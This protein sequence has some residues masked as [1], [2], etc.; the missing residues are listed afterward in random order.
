MF[1]SSTIIKIIV[2]SLNSRVFLNLTNSRAVF[3]SYILILLTEQKL[4]IMV[5]LE[6]LTILQVMNDRQARDA[7]AFTM[8]FSSLEC[9]I[10]R[11]Q[12]L[13]SA[14]AWKSEMPVRFNEGTVVG[15]NLN[16]KSIF[17]ASGGRSQVPTL[18]T[19]L[20]FNRTKISCGLILVGMRNGTCEDRRKDSRLKILASSWENDIGK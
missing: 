13:H 19:P 2:G 3:N 1:L 5:D 4:L 6:A 16:L 18:I 7:T 12:F 9:V 8:I 10:G 17:A 14:T 11:L 15:E 20:L